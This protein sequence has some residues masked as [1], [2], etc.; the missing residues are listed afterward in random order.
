M[1]LGDPTGSCR[2]SNHRTPQQ[3]GPWGAPPRLSV[4]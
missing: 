3:R 2:A 1:V 4:K